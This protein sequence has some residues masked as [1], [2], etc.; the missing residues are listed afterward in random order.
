[1]IICAILFSMI[2]S[3]FNDNQTSIDW[4]GEILSLNPGLVIY[5]HRN[6]SLSLDM[7]LVDQLSSYRQNN[8]KT[9]YWLLLN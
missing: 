4:N 6:D 1:M 8:D 5:F 7:I 2:G 9:K 3:E